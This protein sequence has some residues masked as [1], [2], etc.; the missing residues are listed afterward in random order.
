MV[1][2]L[3]IELIS[4]VSKWGGISLI[5]VFILA[6]NWWKKTHLSLS[7]NKLYIQEQNIEYPLYLRQ[8]T[9]KTPIKLFIKYMYSVKL[10]HV[11]A[12]SPH[13]L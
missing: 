7:F 11:C 4:G 13:I 2:L 9:I 3:D 5:Y 10:F 6:S 8:E 12:V 1:L